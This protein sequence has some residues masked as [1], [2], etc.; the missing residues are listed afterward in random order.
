MKRAKKACPKAGTFGQARP[1]LAP[2]T[3]C[4]MIISNS[5]QNASPNLDGGRRCPP[6]M[7]WELIPTTIGIAWLTCQLFR[8][9][10]LIER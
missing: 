5:R 4:K 3:H 6:P 9:V 8:I 2:R 1:G 10:D 7:F